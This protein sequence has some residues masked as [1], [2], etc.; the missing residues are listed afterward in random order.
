MTVMW[1]SSHSLCPQGKWSFSL[2]VQLT[3]IMKMFFYHSNCDFFH[4]AIVTIWGLSIYSLWIH[5][6]M[7]IS[8]P[9][10]SIFYLILSCL[11]CCSLPGPKAKA[12][13]YKVNIS[14]VKPLIELYSCRLTSIH[15]SPIEQKG[16]YWRR[17]TSYLNLNSKFKWITP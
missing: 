1:K 15:G 12:L 8:V 6:D 14:L 17:Q 3:S 10:N 4:F 16:G 7:H 9:A 13:W 5:F 11:P 2:I